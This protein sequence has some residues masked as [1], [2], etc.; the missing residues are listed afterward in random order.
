MSLT[1]ILYLLDSFY[2]KAVFHIYQTNFNYCQ[3]GNNQHGI[4]I[5]FTNKLFWILAYFIREFKLA[6]HFL[7]LKFL[8]L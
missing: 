3:S 1:F 7:S 5:F 6:N 4:E 2:E 8:Q